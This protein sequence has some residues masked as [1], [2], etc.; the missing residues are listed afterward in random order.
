MNDPSEENT[1]D[2]FCET[3]GGMLK[4][5]FVLDFEDD[6][7][8]LHASDIMDT[9]TPFWSAPGLRHFWKKLLHIFSS[10][11]SSSSPL[12]M[13]LTMMDFVASSVSLNLTNSLA[14]FK[15]SPLKPD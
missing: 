6:Y 8:I 12:S 13:P 4:D 7:W 1:K 14:N 10:K 15:A 9:T 3:G 11:C 2:C 5:S